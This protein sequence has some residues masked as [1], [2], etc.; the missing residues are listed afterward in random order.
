MSTDIHTTIS[1]PFT[2]AQVRDELADF[3]AEHASARALYMEKSGE[4]VSVQPSHQAA[5]HLP[6]SRGIVLSVMQGESLLEV[7]RSLSSL[8]DVHIAKEQ[9]QKQIT[10]LAGLSLATK[11]EHP[12]QQTLEEEKQE[13]SFPLGNSSAVYNIKISAQQKL[14][15]AQEV[16]QEILQSSSLV[17]SAQVHYRQI[18]NKEFYLSRN[19]TLS[20]E[21]QRFEAI[22][23]AI[24]KDPQSGA[25]ARIHDG[26]AKQGGF[27]F[28]NPPR[29]L[30]KKM[31]Q[32]GEKVLQA[33]RLTPAFYDCIFSPSLAGI[34][35]HEAFGHG[36]EADTMRK[37]RAKG[38]QYL[39]KPVASSL[40]NLFDSPTLENEAASYFFDNEGHF[41]CETH[42]VENGILKNPMTD[43]LS[44]RS[45]RLTPTANGRRESYDHKAYTRMSNT[46]FLAGQDTLPDMIASVKEGFYVDRATNGMEDPK[47]WGIQLEALYAERICNGQ[48]TGEVFSP[49]IVT[50]Y[51][52]DI[53]NSIS[54]VSDDM[55]ING[56]G[57][58]GKGHKEWVKV[59]DGGPY[60]KLRARLA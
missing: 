27:E 50:G 16:L 59:T 12:K 55:E 28:M 47:E 49:V 43:V 19:K 3:F 33:K 23:V 48:L 41:A 37:G 52:P 56:L 46:F 5:G 25:S 7:S 30:L 31:L 45:L 18:N 9:L 38:S 34:L 29:G 17:V 14:A 36:T 2:L 26:Y 51:V 54:M 35:A 60:L 11:N 58:C 24:L 42:I 1:F 4:S 44:A 21:I 15:Q 10:A 13:K 39:H 22:F 53:L 6:A 57:M 32:D 40:V 20:Q 8:Q